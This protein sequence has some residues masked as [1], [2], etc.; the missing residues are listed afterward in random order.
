MN[1][2]YRMAVGLTLTGSILA[3]TAFA[4]E[5][6][7]RRALGG[8]PATI[9]APLPEA[10]V[11]ED[12]EGEPED[13]SPSSAMSVNGTWVQ[14]VNLSSPA[15]F[16]ISLSGGRAPFTVTVE[17]NVPDPNPLVYY[18]PENF[19]IFDY[20]VLPASGSSLNG[21]LCGP[22]EADLTCFYTPL[23]VRCL[24][25]GGCGTFSM[26]SSTIMSGR[27]MVRSSVTNKSF[28]YVSESPLCSIGMASGGTPLSDVLA[29]MEPLEPVGEMANVGRVRGAEA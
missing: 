9:S 14:G 23:V 6:I 18:R 22:S 5:F 13:G 26:S 10:P 29:D 7:F 27:P 24:S 16:A 21:K 3:S 1:G 20:S 17:G 12:D 2:I 28:E 8:N 25:D 15:A 11:V 4:Q 19:G